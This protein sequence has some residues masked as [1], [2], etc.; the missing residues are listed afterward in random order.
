MGAVYLYVFCIYSYV[1]TR[2]PSMGLSAC[3]IAHVLILA[4]LALPILAGGRASSIEN[5]W[6]Q[7]NN[8]DTR[9]SRQYI[10]ML[11]YIL[12]PN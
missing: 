4:R 12:T 6:K 10:I 2:A 3:P 8:Y 1:A 11:V 9:Y 5:L 7:L